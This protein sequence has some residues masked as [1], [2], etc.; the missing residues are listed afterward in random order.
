MEKNIMKYNYFDYWVSTGKNKRGLDNL[1]I[2][3]VEQRYKDGKVFYILVGD[4][5][6]P[7][8]IITNLGKDVMTIQ[9]L[10]NN[11]NTFLELEYEIMENIDR[12][13]LFLCRCRIDTI[14]NN[15]RIFCKVVAWAVIDNYNGGDHQYRILEYPRYEDLDLLTN[16][17]EFGEIDT[18]IDEKLF[19]RDYPKFGEWDFM[20]E[21]S[22]TIKESLDV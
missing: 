10:D 1:D 21:D 14:E 17:E 19:W 2:T 22:L 12:D 8:H 15:E 16:I 20:V 6:N 18:P 11:L 4:E 13:R 9:T 3:E 7:S 5:K